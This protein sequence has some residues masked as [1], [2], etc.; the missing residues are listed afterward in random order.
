MQQLEKGKSK[1]FARYNGALIVGLTVIIHIM[2]LYSILKTIFLNWFKT[3]VD[4]GSSGILYLFVFSVF[5][6]G[7]LYYNSKKTEKILN[8]YS[9]DQNPTKTIN[10]IKVISLM[11]IPL[12]LGIILAKRY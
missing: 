7:F 5:G 4:K 2:L 8:R 3:Y 10:Y 11:L 9:D 6:L 1:G 12:I